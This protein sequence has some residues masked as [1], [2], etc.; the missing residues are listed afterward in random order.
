M[1]EQFKYTLI[2]LLGKIDKIAILV[3]VNRGISTSLLSEQCGVTIKLH[4]L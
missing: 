1:R 2:H 4:T 3:P